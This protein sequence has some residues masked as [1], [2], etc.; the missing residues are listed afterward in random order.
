MKT[1]VLYSR[2]NCHLCD[3][4]LAAVAPVIAD[5]ATLEIVDIDSDPALIERYGLRI[6]ILVGGDRELS[7][8]P[9]DT[10]VLERYL[11]RCDG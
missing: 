6:P 9:L 4:L 2:E 5:R 1:L 7:G 11:A 3:R 8:F 10:A